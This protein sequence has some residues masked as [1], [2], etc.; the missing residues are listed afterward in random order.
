MS[1]E[2]PTPDETLTVATSEV[3]GTPSVKS[4]GR[5]STAVKLIQA[6]ALAAVLVPLGSIAM[7]AGS[8][9]YYGGSGQ[10][11]SCAGGTE[12]GALFTF[13][14]APYTLELA[15]ENR[16]SGNFTINV[17]A[18]VKTQ[19][20]MEEEGQLTNP[21]F[22][23]FVC[24]PIA[25]GD[26]CVQFRFSG[27]ITPSPTTWTGFFDVYINWFNDTPFDD[28][29]QDPEHRIRMLHAFEDGDDAYDKDMTFAFN[30]SYNPY[31]EDPAVGGRD[32]MF[33]LMAPFQAPAANV[34][35]P[36]SLLL[37]GTGIGGVL[38]R[39]RQRRLKS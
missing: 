23:N 38:Y 30:S 33:S 12:G 13:G 2:M 36:A 15:F 26:D 14:T 31:K 16:V 39:R 25:G 17:D 3:S 27:D 9:T 34:P 18:E 28:P 35:E 1:D 4:A 11:N 22:T 7:E 5:S 37:L 10:G 29:S 8:C 19:A 24:V 21:L 20:A 32:D 6:A